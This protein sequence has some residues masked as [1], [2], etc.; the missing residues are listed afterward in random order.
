MN[1]PSSS[2]SI[3][4]GN[5]LI[6]EFLGW[7]FNGENPLIPNLYPSYGYESGYTEFSTKVLEFN[8]RWDWLMPVIEKLAKLKLRYENVPEDYYKYPVTFGMTD[9]EGNFMVRLN[10]A[11]LFSAKTLI[12]AAWLAVVD[13]LEWYNSEKG[14]QGSVANPVN[15]GTPAK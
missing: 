14:V 5:K 10:C 15:Q 3:E 12:E 6:A 7:E 11:P 4:E 2:R 8:T 9:E 1:T 13:F